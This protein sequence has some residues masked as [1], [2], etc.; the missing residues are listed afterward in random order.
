MTTNETLT[1]YAGLKGVKLCEIHEFDKG[2]QDC[3]WKMPIVTLEYVPSRNANERQWT[4]DI[5]QPTNLLE[6]LVIDE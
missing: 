5:S 1:V 2:N 4:L 3:Q 6:I